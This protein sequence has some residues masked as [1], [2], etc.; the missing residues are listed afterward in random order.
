MAKKNQRSKKQRSKKQRTKKQ[1]QDSSAADGG[2]L[3]VRR[4]MQYA[5]GARDNSMKKMWLIGVG[6]VVLAFILLV[7]AP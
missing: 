2:L 4:N 5:T 7:L 6:L 3:S 1:N